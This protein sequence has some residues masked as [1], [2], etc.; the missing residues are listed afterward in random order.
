MSERGSIRLTLDVSYRLQGTPLT[1]V[2]EN[3][4]EEVSRALSMGL[5]YYGLA[6]VEVTEYSLTIVPISDPVPEAKAQNY[7]R[8]LLSR[9]KLSLED[10]PHQLV[11][12][13]LMEP[14]AFHAEVRA[15]VSGKPS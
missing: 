6:P 12:L 11:R 1:D 13:G 9:G 15:A 7:F 8:E 3:L 5:L 10:I 14:E 2:V 4:Q